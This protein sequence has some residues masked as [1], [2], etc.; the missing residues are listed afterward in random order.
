MVTM[1]EYWLL[2]PPPP[3]TDFRC[4]LFSPF[5]FPVDAFCQ[6]FVGAMENTPGLRYI[7]S[8]VRPLLQGKVLYT[9]DTPVA[10]LLMKEVK[11]RRE[12]TAFEVGRT[13]L[14]CSRIYE[15]K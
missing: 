9:P 13:L 15:R 4:L 14:G 6:V 8:A 1:C 3:R 10:R 11:S 12:V 2:Y 7:W 5:V